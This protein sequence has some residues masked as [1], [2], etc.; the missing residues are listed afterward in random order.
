MTT[1]H[2][3]A[4]TAVRSNCDP[5]ASESKRLA[6][7]ELRRYI[8]RRLAS[9]RY[10]YEAATLVELREVALGA[11]GF[12]AASYLLRHKADTM[13]A[14]DVLDFIT[15]QIAKS[16]DKEWETMRNAIVDYLNDFEPLR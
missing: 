6:R 7:T 12:N 5:A 14:A 15:H 16:S 2:A 3:P 4:T 8:A 9:A 1:Q 11:L 13:A 10:A